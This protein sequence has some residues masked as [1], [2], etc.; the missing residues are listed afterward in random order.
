MLYAT[1]GIAGG[2]EYIT[3]VKAVQS[4]NTQFEINPILPIQKG[5]CLILFLPLIKRQITGMEY[6]M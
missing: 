3:N 5:P 6:E 4:N 2:K 1:T